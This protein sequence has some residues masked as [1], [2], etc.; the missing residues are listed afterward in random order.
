MSTRRKDGV[1]MC[2]MP[3]NDTVS[4]TESIT[5][6]YLLLDTLPYEGPWIRGV[7]HTLDEALEYFVDN[8][9]TKSLSEQKVSEQELVQRALDDN[10][11]DDYFSHWVE[12]WCGTKNSRFLNRFFVQNG[13]AR[14]THAF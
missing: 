12:K 9:K 1:I 8:V 11:E 7:V 13:A 5:F 6:S 3:K 14:K 4:P 2:G 10:W